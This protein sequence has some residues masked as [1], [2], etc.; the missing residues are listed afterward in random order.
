MCSSDLI[1][2]KPF[3][4]LLMH[5]AEQEKVNVIVRG[6]RAVSDFEDRKSVV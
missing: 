1:E 6:L 3:D 4:T 5:F 2:V